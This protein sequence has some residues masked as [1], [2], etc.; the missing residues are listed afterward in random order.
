MFQHRVS[1]QHADV[2]DGTVHALVKTCIPVHPMVLRRCDMVTIPGEHQQLTT[3]KELVGAPV[4]LPVQMIHLPEGSKT[5]EKHGETSRNMEILQVP[6]ETLLENS[7]VT[8]E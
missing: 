7:R 4:N 8:L 3:I 1:R 5:R 6:L 2:S